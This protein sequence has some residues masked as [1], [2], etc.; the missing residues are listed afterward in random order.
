ML[1][2][3]KKALQQFYKY[4]IVGFVNTAIS[5]GLILILVYANVNPIRANAIGY[6]V[7]FGISFILNRNYTFLASKNSLLI[8]QFLKNVVVFFISYGCNLA[9]I[10]MMSFIKS[11]WVYTNQI[12]GWV[13]FYITGFLGSKIFVFKK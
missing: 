8:N 4:T 9:I 1:L 7:G 13:V 5:I 2:T 6:C 11:E 3:N 10:L 12:I